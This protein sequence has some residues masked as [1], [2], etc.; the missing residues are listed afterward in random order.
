[1]SDRVGLGW[2]PE[3]AAGILAHL[4]R[5]DLVELIADDHFKASPSALRP[6]RTLGEAVPV[7]LHGV[8]QGLASAQR[9]SE[10]RLAGMA[11]LVDAL[12]PELWSEHL[13]FVRADGHEIGHL[14]APPRNAATIEG[15]LANLARARAVVGSTPAVENIATLVEPPGSEMTEGA[16]VG[17]VL[18]GSAACLLL[19]LH[20]L[21]T[22]ALNFGFDPRAWLA[23]LPLSQIGLVHLA[24]GRWTGTL[25]GEEPRW[26]DDHCHAVPDAVFGLLEEVARLCPQP[27]T[28]ILERD[29]AFPPMSELLSELDGARAALRRGRERAAVPQA[30]R[31]VAATP[32]AGLGDIEKARALESL[33]ARLYVDPG[34]LP[35]FLADPGAAARAAGLPPEAFTDVD[36]RGLI[37]AVR[38]FAHKRGKRVQAVPW[39]RRLLAGMERLSFW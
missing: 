31:S 16:W 29:G 36:R 22:N 13:A 23:E 35:D 7:V 21:H 12:R 14:A 4:D 6:L 2:R 5:I 24:G 28:V 3:L 37:L 30:P 38:S 17:A 26:L 8:S 39:A 9:V 33:L 25:D 15:T 27:L 11:R 1:M 34:A 32:N 20:N 18:R 19:D 10:A